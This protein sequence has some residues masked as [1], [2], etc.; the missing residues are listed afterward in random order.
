[1]GDT[2]QHIAAIKT[3]CYHVGARPDQGSVC[4]LTV[5]GNGNLNQETI[6]NRGVTVAFTPN[7]INSINSWTLSPEGIVKN[8]YGTLRRI[9]GSEKAAYVRRCGFASTEDMRK[10]MIDAYVDAENTSFY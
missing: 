8:P 10:A 1:M 5:T 3:F 4:H 7:V 2:E 6:N 9:G